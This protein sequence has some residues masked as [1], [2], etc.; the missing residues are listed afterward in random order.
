MHYVCSDIHGRWNRY[1]AMLGGLNLSGED[2]LY[3]LGDVIDRGE[4]G[5]RILRH[6]KDQ[7]NMTFFPGN[8]ELFLYNFI[9]TADEEWMYTWFCN[10]GEKTAAD[11]MDLKEEEQ[12]EL[13]EFLEESCAVMP[14]LVVGEDHYYLVHAFPDMTYLH[15]PV[16]FS[17]II[18]EEG[19]MDRFYD[20]VWTRID[21]GRTDGMRKILDALKDM[22][23]NVIFG[24]TVTTHFQAR[25][26]WGVP[27]E[28][29]WKDKPRIFYGDNFTCID[30]GCAMRDDRGCLGVLRL[31]DGKE[32]YF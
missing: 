31:E 16:S 25:D 26:R 6:I 10:G 17:Q 5:I 14:D 19:G 28:N 1:E 27:R 13:L 9:Y 21:R 24:H 30:C 7:P 4:S 12:E 8:H 3:I 22:G 2:H 23:R 29:V 15:E 11:F 32:F 18:R 20:M